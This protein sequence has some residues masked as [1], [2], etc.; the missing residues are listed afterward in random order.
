MQ[1]ALIARDDE[2]GGTLEA[3]VDGLTAGFVTGKLIAVADLDAAT[4]QR[5]R[6][7]AVE[8]EPLPSG[9]RR[10][11]LRLADRQ[12]ALR[13]PLRGLSFLPSLRL[14]ATMVLQRFGPPAERRSVGGQLHLLYPAQGLVVS[15]EGSGAEPARAVIQYV[16]P[17]RF[18]LLRGPLTA[19]AAASAGA[20]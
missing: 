15:L 6:D 14:D 20:S 5:L 7:Q 8:R 13:A 17:A 12:Q 11:T 19:P 10:Y 18:D 9:A 1:L 3:Y 4:A 2:P 16:A